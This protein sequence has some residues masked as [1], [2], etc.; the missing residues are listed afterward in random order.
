MEIKLTNYKISQ[1]AEQRYAERLLGKDST[2]DAN[3]FIVENKEKIK[4]D[5][6]K[7][8][9]Y[10]E[11]IFE[12]KQSQ[13]DGKGKVLNV[14]L[15][16][17]YVILVDIKAELVVTVYK[18]DLGCGDDFNLQYIDKMMEKLNSKKQTLEDAK[19]HTECDNATYRD[20]LNETQAQINQY[21]SM[22][23]NLEEMCS[24]YQL[25]MDNNKVSVSQAN[26]EV[27][28]VVNTLIGKREF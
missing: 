25:I 1:H 18:I 22:I 19:L 11:C 5:L 8:V 10:G 13:K 26:M 6:N 15:K 24:G 20:L 4:T 12:G 2:L 14:Y 17:T 28:E 3:K 7:M 9:S 21:K 16:D 27:A 23:K